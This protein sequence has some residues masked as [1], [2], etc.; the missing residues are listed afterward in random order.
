MG[1]DGIMQTWKLTTHPAFKLGKLTTHLEMAGIVPRQGP[2]WGDHFPSDPGR[3]RPS[4]TS[5][6]LSPTPGTATERLQRLGTVHS[7]SWRWKIMGSKMF[8][9]MEHVHFL[10][11]LNLANT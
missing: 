6:I 2:G 11:V 3:T 5:M 1:N 9:I 8:K 4:S 7:P 10:R